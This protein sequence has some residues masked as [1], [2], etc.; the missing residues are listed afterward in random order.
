M[1]ENLI[2]NLEKRGARRLESQNSGIMKQERGYV[3]RTFFE[4]ASRNGGVAW[5]LESKKSN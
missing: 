5:M 3:F 4:I 2:S 1:L